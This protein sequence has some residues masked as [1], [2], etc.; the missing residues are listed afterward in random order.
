MIL[1]K[2]IIDNKNSP[3]NLTKFSKGNIYLY[4]ATPILRKD[5]VDFIK[6]KEYLD[7]NTWKNDRNEIDLNELLFLDGNIKF[8]TKYNKEY[9]I[10]L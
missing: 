5:L 6:N 7:S 2:K 1:F 8:I 10:L 3:L 9:S 4:F